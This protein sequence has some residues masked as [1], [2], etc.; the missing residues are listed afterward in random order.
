MS[1]I[2]SIFLTLAILLLFI[3]IFVKVSRGLRKGG[4][5]MTTIMYGATDAFYHKDK[6]KA[7]E[8]IV[9]QKAGKRLEEQSSEDPEN[10]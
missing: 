8:V 1:D 3:G 10:K 7:I 4:G 2:F 6:K 5:S 9:E